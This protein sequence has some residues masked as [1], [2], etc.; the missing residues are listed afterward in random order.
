[1]RMLYSCSCANRHRH[2]FEF[3][4][5]KNISPLRRTP[6]ANPRTLHAKPKKL[7]AVHCRDVGILEYSIFLF[8][9]AARGS[10][11]S[12]ICA[13]VANAPKKAARPTGGCTMPGG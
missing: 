8:F 12:R 11:Q 10:G 4:S 3:D 13:G 1:M 5:R 9:S 6:S 2:A 7:V